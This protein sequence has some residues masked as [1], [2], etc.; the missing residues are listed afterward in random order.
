MFKIISPSLLHNIQ[1]DYDKITFALM[2]ID[3]YFKAFFFHYYVLNKNILDF[4]CA[5]SRW[6]IANC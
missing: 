3:L 1:G 5:G 4:V 2:F 6:T